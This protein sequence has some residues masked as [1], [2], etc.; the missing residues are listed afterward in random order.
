LCDFE[1]RCTYNTVCAY[2]YLFI[3][4]GCRKKYEQNEAKRQAQIAQAR[5]RSA[6]AKSG[7]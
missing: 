4:S 5:Q 2:F 7:S 3:F 6:F 1:R